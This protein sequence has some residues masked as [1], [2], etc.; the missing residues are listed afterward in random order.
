MCMDM[1]WLYLVKIKYYKLDI[2]DCEESIKYR[3]KLKM[4][5]SMD[6]E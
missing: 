4:N 5:N 1:D 2:Y 3:Y 6:T